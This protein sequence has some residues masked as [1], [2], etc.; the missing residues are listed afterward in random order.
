MNYVKTKDS[1][2]RE[3]WQTGAQR[4]TNE[5]KPRWDSIPIRHLD[6]YQELESGVSAAD[7]VDKS[8]PPITGTLP[9]SID[10]WH[11]T[12]D[13]HVEGNVVAPHPD[14]R[15]DLIPDIMLNR[16]AHL[17][18]RGARKYDDNNWKKGIPLARVWASLLR[19]AFAWIMG[20]RS[21]DHLAAIIWNATTLMWT[22]TEIVEGRL[23]VELADAG[24][25]TDGWT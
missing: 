17:Y 2:Q 4:D 15:P 10:E 22:E 3:T 12:A 8:G 9:M 25:L 16:L 20:D 14:Y 6:W 5:G 7:L 21:E 11:K 23:P 1:G 18:G 24:P 19:H 13:G